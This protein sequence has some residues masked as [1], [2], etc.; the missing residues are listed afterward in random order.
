MGHFSLA[1][2]DEK[3]RGSGEPLSKVRAAQVPPGGMAT[4]RVKILG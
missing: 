4:E 1:L 3:E 2:E